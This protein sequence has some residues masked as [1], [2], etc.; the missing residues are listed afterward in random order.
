ME[1]HQDIV[2]QKHIHKDSN[3]LTTWVKNE[4]EK[5][6]QKSEETGQNFLQLSAYLVTEGQNLEPSSSGT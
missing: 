1:E 5:E 4:K 3:K 2:K 6:K